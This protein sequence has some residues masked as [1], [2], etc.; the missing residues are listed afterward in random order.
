MRAVIAGI[1]NKTSEYIDELEWRL[2]YESRRTIVNSAHMLAELT[3]HLG[4]EVGDPSGRLAS[5]SKL[6]GL[7]SPMPAA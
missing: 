1:H 7:K 3:D 5:R 6:N 4:Y 2:I